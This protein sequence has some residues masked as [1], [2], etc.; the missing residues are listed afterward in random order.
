[1][2]YSDRMFLFQM[3][4]HHRLRLCTYILEVRESEGGGS[5]RSFGVGG[6]QKSSWLHLLHLNLHHAKALVTCCRCCTSC[7]ST[8]TMQS[9]HCMMHILVAASTIIILYAYIIY[10]VQSPVAC[11]NFPAAVTLL[12]AGALVL[13]FNS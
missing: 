10:P 2:A 9:L 6:C 5:R 7:T 3:F 4:T 11:C 12:R 1:M 13:F 8:Y